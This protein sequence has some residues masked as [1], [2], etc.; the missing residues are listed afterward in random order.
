[1]ESQVTKKVKILNYF[2]LRID[3]EVKRF[4]CIFRKGL[5]R[6]NIL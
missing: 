6:K 1:M 3:M 4:S 5:L 2:L